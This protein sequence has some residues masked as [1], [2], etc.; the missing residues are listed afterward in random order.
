M[1]NWL[2]LFGTLVIPSACSPNGE[3]HGFQEPTPG[4]GGPG[5]SG[6]APSTTAATGPG[7]GG[8]NLTGGSTGSGGIIEC[9]PGGPDDDVDK[10]GFTPNQGDCNDCDP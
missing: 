1:R 7:V 10:D 8:F 3:T 2:F 4:Q 9:T 6:G 5:G